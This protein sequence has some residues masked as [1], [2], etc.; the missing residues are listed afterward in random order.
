MKNRTTCLSN[1][2]KHTADYYIGLYDDYLENQRGL[3]LSYRRR[4]C[5]V[6][7]MFLHACFGSSPIIIKLI[8]P[9][10]ISDFVY[11]YASH[12][13]QDSAQ[14]LASILRSFLRFLRFKNLMVSDLS[15]AVPTI[16]GW[17]GDRMPAYLSDQEVNDLLKHC[18]KSTS[19]GL[20]TYTIIIL[21]LSLG[22]RA[23]EVAK[24]TLDDIDWVNGEIIIKGKG[25]SE[26][27]LPLT[28][29]LGDKLVLYLRKG[30]PP[31][32]LR[33][34]F[35]LPQRPNKELT[36]MDIAYIIGKA[37]RC[38]GLKK[39]GKAH[40]LR[41]TFATRLLGNGASLQEIGRLLRHKSI[42][43]TSIYAKVDF[44]RLRSLAMPWPGNLIF[45]GGK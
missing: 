35:I 9:K 13:T 1:N 2:K 11:Q 15:L 40:L 21:I 16:A 34:F 42:N 7:E 45:G 27:C 12:L 32:S 4:L 19:V 10:E 20:M 22:L 3:S 26:S 14:G 28:Q 29:D 39:K 33:F 23:F 37:F 30:R 5:T 25:S 6:A 41:H 31:C 17:K 36:S 18:D 24:L 8:K 44:N 38:A 43:T